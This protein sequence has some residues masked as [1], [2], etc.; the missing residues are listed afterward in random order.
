MNEWMSPLMWLT[1]L[2]AAAACWY[3]THSLMLR[4]GSVARVLSIM[5]AIALFTPAFMPSASGTQAM[6]ML[7]A[8]LFQAL[9][10]SEMGMLRAVMPALFVAGVYLIIDAYWRVPEKK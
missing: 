2:S 10:K 6:P 1:Y 7:F 9:A 5:L 8:L 3:L 4:K